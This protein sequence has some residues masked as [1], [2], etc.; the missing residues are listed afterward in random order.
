LKKVGRGDLLLLFERDVSRG[1][2]GHDVGARGVAVAITRGKRNE[3]AGSAVGSALLF[4]FL[5]ASAIVYMVLAAQ[6]ESFVHPFTI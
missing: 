4:A 6:F 2:D 1:N 5:L 3:N